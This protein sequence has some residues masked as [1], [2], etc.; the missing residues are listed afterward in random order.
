MRDE[1]REGAPTPPRNKDLPLETPYYEEQ[2]DP[3]FVEQ[4]DPASNRENQEVPAES[5]EDWYWR[6][7]DNYW[8]EEG[9]WPWPEPRSRRKEEERPPEDREP[10]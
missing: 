3:Y 4:I 9:M 10:E 2:F 6:E 1:W 8:L 5:E 7:P